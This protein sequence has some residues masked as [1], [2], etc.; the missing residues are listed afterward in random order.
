[1]TRF[2]HEPSCPVEALFRVLMGPW[3]MY[4][5]W[6]LRE[7]GPLRFGVLKRRLHNV[8]AKVLTDRL[9]L[10]EREG[11]IYREHKPTRSASGLF[12]ISPRRAIM[13]SVILGSS[14]RL[15]FTTRPYRKSW[16]TT[17]KPLARYGAMGKAR[18]AS[19]FATTGE[20]HHVPRHDRQK[21]LS[22]SGRLK[23]HPSPRSAAPSPPHAYHRSAAGRV[24]WFSRVKSSCRQ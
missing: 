24:R 3:T 11:L 18:V 10:L 7:D 6:T 9:R 16:M 19:G 8:S 23:G 12:S 1:M 14:F 22:R 4:I 2:S 21:Q 13:S 17:A 5:L 15:S 20:L